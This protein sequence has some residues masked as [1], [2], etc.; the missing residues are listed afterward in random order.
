MA[1]T[2]Q[3]KTR[4]DGAVRDP[5]WLW[6]SGLAII[7]ILGAGLV[8]YRYFGPSLADLTGTAARPTTSMEPVALDVGGERFVAA[9]AYILFPRDR[10]DGERAQVT[11]AG[12]LPGLEP[13]GDG[14]RI[15]F[16]APGHRVSDVVYLWLQDEA[17]PET[18][19]LHR[20]FTPDGPALSSGLLPGIPRSGDTRAMDAYRDVDIF[21]AAPGEGESEG[22][23]E[24]V[25]EGG[26]ESEGE[27]EI[28]LR[29]DKPQP[30]PD[31]RTFSRP[32][33]RF[34][35]AFVEGVR[36]GYRFDRGHLDDWR[37]VHIQA[38]TLMERFH[39]GP[40]SAS[41]APDA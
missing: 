36:F 19:I 24:G 28:I 2:S 31:T 20:L 3:D 16:R 18:G 13:Y 5:L 23:S 6:L 39:A 27:G 32:Y 35:G 15:A 38:R 4:S 8:V 37:S 34:E 17:S 12:V 25:G 9:K 29:C 7:V 33:C 10:T 26:G 41:Q 11:F 22:K 40:V 30:V 14:T 1:S 21:F